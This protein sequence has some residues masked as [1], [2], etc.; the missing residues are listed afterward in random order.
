MLNVI[1]KFQITPELSEEEEVVL[2]NQFNDLTSIYS[3]V[4]NDQ[5]KNWKSTFPGC[6]DKKENPY[7]DFIIYHEMIKFLKSNQTDAVFLT[8]D[9]EKTTKEIMECETI[10]SSSLHGVIVSHAYQIPAVWIKF[11]DK[12]SGDNV[13]FYDPMKKRFFKDFSEHDLLLHTLIGDSA[14]NIPNIKYNNIGERIVSFDNM[15]K[16]SKFIWLSGN[17]NANYT[18]IRFMEKNW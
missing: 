10:I 7:G 3:T 12:L 13:K 5:N 18:T 1:S 2:K 8:N 16:C 14:G 15:Y 9:V 17:I 11:S 4:K 6:G